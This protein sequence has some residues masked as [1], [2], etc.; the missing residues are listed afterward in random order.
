MSY[1]HR[2][3]SGMREEMIRKERQRRFCLLLEDYSNQEEA[4]IALGFASLS[5]VSNYKN[6]HK[7]MGEKVARQIE[8]YA[9]LPK[10]TFVE[11][12]STPWLGHDSSHLIDNTKEGESGSIFQSLKVVEKPTKYAQIQ[13]FELWRGV[14]QNETR[15]MTV[16]VDLLDSL[17]L[18]AGN[19]RSIEMPDESQSGRIRKGD[20]IAINIKF[21]APPKNNAMYAVKLGDQYTLRRF[22]YRANGGITLS[23]SNPD[24]PDESISSDEINDLDI[25]GEFALFQGTTV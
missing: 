4:A 9:N 14:L 12:L 25:L 20:H 13:S 17:G 3:H 18:R 21:E 8:Q 7:I 2:Y 19:L 11:P 15:H 24:Y 10:G 1:T 23:C 6:G 22:V 16:T 5:P